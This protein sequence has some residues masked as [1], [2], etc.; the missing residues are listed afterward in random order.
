[1]AT[2]FQDRKHA[3][4]ELVKI[5]NSIVINN[6][7]KELL[8]LAIPRGGIIIGDVIASHFHCNLDI[9]VSRKIGAEFNSELAIGAVMPDNSY[10]INEQII[11]MIPSVSQNYIENQIKIEK[12]E[13][14]RR[15]IEFRGNSQYNDKL[16]GKDVLLVDDGIATG[17]TIIAAARWIKNK[18]NC[19]SLIVAVP[20]APAKDR[21]AM[22]SLKDIANKV[23]VSHFAEEFFGVGQFYKIFDQVSNTDVKEIMKKYGYNII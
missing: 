4:E 23:I 14:D 1:M 18:Y 21:Y 5:L 8:V 9:V 16:N 15:L 13:I 2:L 12:K 22:N 7:K 3:A 10:F 19:K 6:N 11:N 17:A 20:V